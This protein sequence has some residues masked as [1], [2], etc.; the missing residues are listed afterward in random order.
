MDV[1]TIWES[2]EYRVSQARTVY[3]PGYLLVERRRGRPLPW[4]ADASLKQALKLA[5]ALLRRRINPRKIFEVE[6]AEGPAGSIFHV[7]P[8]TDEVLDAIGAAPGN[9][10][11][12]GSRVAESVRSTYK[13]GGTIYGAVELLNFVAEARH[14][15]R[16]LEAG[17]SA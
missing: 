13:D 1:L 10:P 12:E 11:Q 5:R 7:I 16:E 14:L 4:R 3:L 8:G 17:G 9:T 15:C 2:A 6:L